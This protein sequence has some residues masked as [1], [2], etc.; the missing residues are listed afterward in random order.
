MSDDDGFSIGEEN[1]RMASVLA[2]RAALALEIK[3]MRRHGR[4]ARTIAQEFLNLPGRPGTRTVYAKL[5]AY[6][7]EQIGAN[8][9]KPL[10]PPPGQL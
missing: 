1:T 8:F 10:P 6:I 4:S 5:N 9:D 2:L 3:G 7:V